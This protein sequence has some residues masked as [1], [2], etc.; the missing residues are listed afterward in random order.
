[1]FIVFLI[2]AA[3]VL[4]S[5][6]LFDDYYAWLAPE[7]G[8]KD[9]KKLI[10]SREFLAARE[11]AEH[12]A[13]RTVE[14]INRRE[15]QPDG[16]LSEVRL[17]PKEGAVTLLRNDPET[18]GSRLFSQHCASCHRY[19]DQHLEAAVQGI[20]DNST[21]AAFI[22]PPAGPSSAPNLFGFASR[23]W[24]KNLLN[25]EQIVGPN[26]F[27]QTAHKMGR[28]ATWLK[29][30]TDSLKA[31][32]I[33]AIAAALSAQAELHSQR[34]ADKVDA[35]LITRG[36]DL[37]EQNCTRG[38]HRFGN[39]GQLGLAPDLTGYGSYEWMMGLVSD[40]TYERF[41]RHE[42]DRMPSFAKDLAHPENN[43]LSIREISLIVDWLRGDY[44]NSKDKQPVL[45]HDEETAKETVALAR[46]TANPWTSIVG[47]AKPQPESD[48]DRAQRL[49]ASN[50][51]VCHGT[52][53]R[54]VSEGDAAKRSAP[55]LANFGSREWLTGL[56]DPEQIKSPRYF[57][58]TRHA[59]GEM[60]EFVVDNL[61]ELDDADKARLQTL[62]AA[63]S[64]E[65]ALPS[66]AET[67][68]TAE[69][70]GTLTKG[71]K[72]LGEAFESSSC[73]DCHKFRDQGDLGSAPDL[74]GWAS[75][76]WLVRFISDPTHEAFYRETNDR[77]PAFGKSS[78][79][80]NKQSLLSAADI[81]LIA[82]LIR[83]ELK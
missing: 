71:R 9:E 5:M 47:A 3:G 77:M 49:F 64:A 57:G 81:E 52:L 78:G 31:D 75:K 60:A 56:L 7:L 35:E 68:K 41:Y 33:D 8:L 65:A 26:Y 79:G 2:A 62:I 39:H 48:L 58:N 15:T 72:A 46:T 1:V 16:T 34:E 55:S 42:N 43:S 54:S 44:Y 80:P 27:G 50:C 40:P 19:L 29:Q 61:K 59:K 6:A 51:T 14:L 22:L 21:V 67:D 32:E 30:H 70:D 36:V 20:T 63:L 38:C 53:A 11:A 28:M 4:T 74:T 45:P 18:R 73:T 66:Q 23:S 69:A 12:D 82:R 83:G 13:E 76:D 17:I 10:A 24:V 37:I 25:A